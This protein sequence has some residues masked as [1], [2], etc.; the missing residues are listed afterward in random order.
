V[1]NVPD[2]P[3]T[4]GRALETRRETVYFLANLIQR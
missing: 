3:I 2:D 4:V 1:P